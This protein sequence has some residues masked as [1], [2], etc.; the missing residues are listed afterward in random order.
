MVEVRAVMHDENSIQKIVF[1]AVIEFSLCN[2]MYITRRLPSRL[3]KLS[4]FGDLRGQ[5]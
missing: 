4:Q 2:R 3:R 1:E 5:V